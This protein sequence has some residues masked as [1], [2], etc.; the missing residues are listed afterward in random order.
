MLNSTAISEG[1]KVLKEHLI[2]RL[3]W[4]SLT[5]PVPVYMLCSAQYVSHAMLQMKDATL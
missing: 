1:R 2:W 3:W 5:N 4:L